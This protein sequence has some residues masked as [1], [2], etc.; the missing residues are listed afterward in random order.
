M[1]NLEREPASG[2]RATAPPLQRNAFF[3]PL[4]VLRWEHERQL[5]TSDWLLHQ[6]RYEWL[7]PLAEFVDDL[8]GF[9]TQDLVFHHQDEEE[10]L[11]PTLQKR[12]RPSDSVEALLAELVRDHA[13]EGFLMRD[14]VTDLR[15]VAKSNE[16]EDPGRFFASL[17]IFA[18]GQ[19]RHL[20]WENEVLL[21][22]AKLRLTE[23]DLE[24]LARSMTERRGMTDPA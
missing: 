15:Q 6:A 23:I 4:D 2:L 9:L 1:S 13:T 11:L 10:D 24:A 18:E 19:K 7:E 12:C 3:R 5:Q 8:L 21:P 22:L 17:K 16:V 14:I 20:I